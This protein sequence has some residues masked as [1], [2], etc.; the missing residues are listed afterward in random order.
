LG[1]LWSSSPPL[2]NE[3]RDPNDVLIEA[4]RLKKKPAEEA[5]K[6]QGKKRAGAHEQK[7]K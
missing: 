7:Q 6:K 1:A 2:G 5:A 3:F 4:K